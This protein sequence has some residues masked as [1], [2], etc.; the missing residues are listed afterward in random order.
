MASNC[1][2]DILQFFWDLYVD[3]KGN[4]NVCLILV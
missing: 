2:L 1:K 3:L 4:V